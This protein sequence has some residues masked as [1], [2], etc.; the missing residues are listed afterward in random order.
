MKCISIDLDGTLLNS[1]HEIS[2]ENVKTLK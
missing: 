1:Q 2:E